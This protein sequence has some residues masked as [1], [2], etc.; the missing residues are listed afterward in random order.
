MSHIGHSADDRDWIDG[1]GQYEGWGPRG[2]YY[3]D[4]IK[5]VVAH[6]IKFTYTENERRIVNDITYLQ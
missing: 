2:S 1:T 4:D 5:K 3:K 6:K